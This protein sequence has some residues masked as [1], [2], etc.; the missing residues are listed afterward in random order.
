LLLLSASVERGSEH[1][2]AGDLT[3]AK[4]RASSRRCQRFSPLALRKGVDGIVNGPMVALGNSMLMSEF[5]VASQGLTPRRK[6]RG[7][8]RHRV[9][10]A[11]RRRAPPAIIAIAD[12]VK[13]SLMADVIKKLARG[14]ACAV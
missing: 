6:P 13:A 3:A 2:R 11:R 14:T 7:R 4:E 10:V 12:P 9:Y 8:M 1:P 5:E